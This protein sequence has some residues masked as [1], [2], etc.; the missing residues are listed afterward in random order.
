M[1]IAYAVGAGL[2]LFVGSIEDIR[3]RRIDPYWLML[4]AGYALGA[5]IWFGELY[6]GLAGITI[7]IL[8]LGA[9]FVSRQKV[10]YG[11][12]L[13]FAVCGLYLGFWENFSLL[14]L[15]LVLCA[16]G[17]LALMAVG[18][19]K[20]GQALPFVPFV[21]CAFICAVIFEAGG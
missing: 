12:G 4:N 1:R 5:R 11:D 14:F 2:L 6:A 7:G 18:K 15:S 8:L 21:L 20:K 19:V 13:V 3:R 9:A 17:G 10:G 16:L